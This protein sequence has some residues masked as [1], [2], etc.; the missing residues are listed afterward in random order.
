M[1]VLL[2]Q[3]G[4]CWVAIYIYTHTYRSSS[5]DWVEALYSLFL[6]SVELKSP[7]HIILTRRNPAAAAA[8]LQPLKLSSRWKALKSIGSKVSRVSYSAALWRSLAN[9]G[10]NESRLTMRRDFA[11]RFGK[12]KRKAAISICAAAVL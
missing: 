4:D 5:I 2:D 12:K 11:S 9:H 10:H 7:A 8:A 1:C 6:L 3:Q